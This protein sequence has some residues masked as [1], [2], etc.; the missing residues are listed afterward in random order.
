MVTIMEAGLQ[1][2]KTKTEMDWVELTLGAYCLYALALVCLSPTVSAV[3][4]VCF[5]SAAFPHL[6][7]APFVLG[8][9]QNHSLLSIMSDDICAG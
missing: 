1:S 9:Q 6:L 2:S 8:K 7:L 3:W 4:T 5:Y